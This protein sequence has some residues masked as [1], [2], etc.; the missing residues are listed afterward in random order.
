MEPIDS[1]LIE[2]TQYTEQA[3]LNRNVSVASVPWIIYA[4]R[5]KEFF[6]K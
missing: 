5:H 1:P 4:L 2:T 3:L 6:H